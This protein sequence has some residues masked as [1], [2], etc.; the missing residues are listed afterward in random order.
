MTVK[1]LE[2]KNLSDVVAIHREAYDFQHF[3]SLMSD[4]M[5]LSYYRG[6]AAA[7]GINVS[8]VLYENERPAGFVICGQGLNH[9]VKKFV[10]REIL[11]MVWVLIKNPRL[12]RQKT[13]AFFS[14]FSKKPS[15][16]SVAS[17][18]LLS[19]AVLPEFQGHGV[20]KK[21]LLEL[22]ERLRRVDCTV[23]GLSVKKI[24][25]KAILFYLSS[26]FVLE[27]SD[28]KSEY[29]TKRLI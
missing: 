14:R 23:Y 6:L 5:L 13:K 27:F 8:F 24:N 7:P 10:E 16:K 3:T 15:W 19:I 17:V 29:Y 12:I 22:E 28:D 2:L 20:G 18:R 25:S 21:L 26:G 4:D 1:P 11:R 9:V